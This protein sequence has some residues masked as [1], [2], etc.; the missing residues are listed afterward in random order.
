MSKGT[1]IAAEIAGALI[2]VGVETGE[3][4]LYGIIVRK[5]EMTGPVYD[6]VYGP[7][8]TYELLVMLDT[9]SAFERLDTAI[10]K[11]DTKIIAQAGTVVPTVA[12]DIVID[13][14]IYDVHGV[15]PLNPGGVDLMYEVW[16]RS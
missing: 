2:E 13:D 4:P 15:E 12:D 7:P 6:P 1:D 16:A 3:G 11:T 9:F 14:I 10:E 5:G 8:T